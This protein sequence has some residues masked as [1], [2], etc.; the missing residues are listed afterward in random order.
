[1]EKLML[2]LLYQHLAWIVLKP[3]K[4]FLNFLMY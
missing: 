1:M 2:I 3:K 4:P